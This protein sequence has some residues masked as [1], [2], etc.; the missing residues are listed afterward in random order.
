MKRII[1]SL[2]VASAVAGP[3]AASATDALAQ[4]RERRDDRW[5]DGR[6][7]ARRWEDREDRRD[8]GA[9][10][11]DRRYDSW[12][13]GRHNG[14]YYNNRWYYGPPPEAYFDSPQYRPGYLA[15]RRGSSLPPYYRGAI[16]RDYDRYHLRKPPAGYAWYRV[17]DDYLLT[18]IA[19][20]II[21]D[22]IGED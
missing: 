7:D 20:G 10:R 9:D 8:R 14:Y 5:Q 6:Y 19:S 17:G 21:F 1:V 3:M 16:V 4:S 22:I 11:R 18:G 15:W 2:A 12:D 13:R